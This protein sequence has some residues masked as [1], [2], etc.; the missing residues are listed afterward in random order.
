MQNSFQIGDREFARTR[1]RAEH[2]GAS[3]RASRL[4]S[5]CVA[6]L[7]PF[8]SGRRLPR[9]ND[10][11]RRTPA[12]APYPKQRGFPPHTRRHVERGPRDR[13]RTSTIISIAIKHMGATRR[14]GSLLRY[15]TV[16]RRPGKRRKE[17]DTSA[18]LVTLGSSRG[19]GGPFGGRRGTHPEMER[20]EDGRRRSRQRRADDESLRIETGNR[21]GTVISNSRTRRNGSRRRAYRWRFPRIFNVR[22]RWS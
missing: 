7:P 6:S 15:A 1:G 10:V 3:A 16:F 9:T 5:H 21:P 17:A 12:A 4:P 19:C 11:C 8:Q 20:R 2:H 14:D 22:S 13:T 18:R